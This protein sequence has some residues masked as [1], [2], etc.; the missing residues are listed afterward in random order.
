MIGEMA[1]VSG[2]TVL[3][4]GVWCERSVVWCILG[5][6]IYFLLDLFSYGNVSATIFVPRVL[7]S[8]HTS[9]PCLPG[10]F[11]PR[12]RTGICRPS[13]LQLYIVQLFIFLLAPA[14]CYRLSQFAIWKN[15]LAVL[16]RHH[17]PSAQT[18]CCLT[19]H[20]VSQPDATHST[21]K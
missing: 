11:T 18:S 5:D 13:N 14:I 19:I 16:H 20:K 7:V 2:V 3:L 8:S 4:V 21:V 1:V 15:C 17:G 10:S 6:Q 9:H 12:L